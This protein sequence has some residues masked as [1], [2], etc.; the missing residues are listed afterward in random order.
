[1]DSNLLIV[2]THVE[3]R[4]HE[5]D[6][7]LF[8]QLGAAT[9][10]LRN[11]SFV[12]LAGCDTAALASPAAF[13]G[14]PITRCGERYTDYNTEEWDVCSSGASGACAAHPVNGTTLESIFCDCPFPEMR[15]PAVDDGALAPYLPLPSLDL[16]TGGCLTPMQ[17]TDV[18]VISKRV[19]VA[20][21]KSG[22]AQDS[23]EHAVNVTLYVTGDD[24]ARPASWR[25]LNA[26]LVQESIARRDGAQWLR[27]PSVEAGVDA[28]RAGGTEVLVPLVLSAAGLRE[29]GAPYQ[30]T[31]AIDVRSSVE[32]VARTV[33]LEVALSVQAQTSFVEWGRVAPP[34]RCSRSSSD[35]NYTLSPDRS[36]TVSVQSSASFTAC[37]I[38]RIPVDHQLPSPTDPRSFAVS[39]N[40]SAQ[41]HA[42][43]S[44]IEYYHGGIYDIYF[45]VP[46]HGAFTIELRLAGA[47]IALLVGG[48]ACPGDRVPL[49]DGS[50]GCRMGSSP[51]PIDSLLG[52]PPCEPCPIN[53]FKQLHGHEPCQ[54]CPPG[55]HQPTP[56]SS[57]C[58]PCRN[59][60]FFDADLGACQPCAVNTFQPDMAGTT[61]QACPSGHHQPAAGSTLCLPCPSGTIL[62]GDKGTCEPCPINTFQ[63][64]P[65]GQTCQ[66]CQPGHHQPAAGS[67]SCV[68]C[69]AGEYQP[70]HGEPC[71]RCEVG[72]DSLNGSDACTI[73]ARGYYRP[74]AD[75][76][77]A[78]CR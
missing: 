33:L 69:K 56:G 45:T 24:A 25:V 32:A 9:M 48:A 4:Q 75:S 21:S 49:S 7:T 52:L 76:P 42:A 40:A 41:H 60:T 11:V 72:R 23:M 66:R 61:C 20:L 44:R 62:D 1:M 36:S 12:A 68:P 14:V 77:A 6:G 51:A 27:L 2:F 22:A 15:D 55:H 10:V 5:C 50:C 53:T 71:K 54:S 16:R 34:Q 43:S 29:R 19:V 63:P 59:G 35:H 57:S 67:A 18:A 47:P 46:T 17:L 78:D 30:E 31:L 8:S 28:V 74:R 13:V 65:A 39:L 64:S 38:E 70:T 26:T 73:C 37:D 3:F 58:V